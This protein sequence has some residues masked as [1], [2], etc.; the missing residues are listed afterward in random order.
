VRRGGSTHVSSIDTASGSA[1]KDTAYACV[2]RSGS[3]EPVGP[4]GC[5]SSFRA[6]QKSRPDLRRAG[7][8]RECCGYPTRVGNASSGDNRYP[9]GV[10]YY[11]DQGDK[12]NQLAF[13]CRS[14]KT[15]AMPSRL[16]T[17]CN[18]HVCACGFGGARL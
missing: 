18:Y 4:S 1:A 6:A 5:D 17:L 7:P 16:C 13:G 2:F 12:S 10:D 15:A 8:E 11:G 9:H 3:A 14:I